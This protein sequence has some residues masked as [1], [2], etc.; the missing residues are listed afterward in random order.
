MATRKK[1]TTKKRTTKKCP[2]YK[3]I[4][5]DHILPPN[6]EETLLNDMAK[7]GWSLHT[8]NGTRYIFIK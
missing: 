4:Q 7:E 2:V 5:Y 1:S 3:V 6:E 8:I